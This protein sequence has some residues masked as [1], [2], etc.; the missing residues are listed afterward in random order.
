MSLSLDALFS[1]RHTII[2]KI[3]ALPAL[4][5]GTV[6]TRT[7]CCGKPTCRCHRHPQYQHVQYQ[8]TAKVDGKTQS[9]NLHLDHHTATLLEQT[10]AY[11]R[12]LALVDEYVRV[13]E[14]IADRLP[15]E[16]ALTEREIDILKKKLQT[17]SSKRP[18]KNFTV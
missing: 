16:P 9:K 10:Q 1:Q 14:Q 13:S 17:R 7:R 3:S 4:R 11:H 2:E 18:R 5:R 15:A 6:L 8:W 12:F